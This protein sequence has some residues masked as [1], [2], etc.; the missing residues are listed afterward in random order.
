MGLCPI[1]FRSRVLHCH[2]IYISI[3]SFGE[4]L[5]RPCGKSWHHGFW[6]P[7]LWRR[8]QG[9]EWGWTVWLGLIWQPAR[10]SEA[11]MLA[12]SKK[13]LLR[14]TQL[15]IISAYAATDC[16]PNA[17][18]GISCHKLHDRTCS[19]KRNGIVI[20]A[21][22]ANAKAVRWSSYQAHFGVSFSLDFYFSE[23]S[24][25]LVSLE[26]SWWRSDNVCP[27]VRK[28]MFEPWMR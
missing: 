27:S 16:N 10:R 2:S 25:I 14:W 6:S 20:L 15:F 18:K 9:V 13:S 22:D 17:I 21:G 19:A 24:L 23:H 11:W 8:S 3:Q 5:A 7:W 4:V 1:E 12:Q 28:P 26:G